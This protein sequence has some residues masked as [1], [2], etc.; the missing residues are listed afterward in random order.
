MWNFLR[1]YAFPLR[2]RYSDTFRVHL[3]QQANSWL[4]VKPLAASWQRYP[5]VVLRDCERAGEFVL[6]DSPGSEKKK[7]EKSQR[8]PTLAKCRAL[9]VPNR[10]NWRCPSHRPSTGCA[11]VLASERQRLCFLLDRCPSSASSS[12]SLRSSRAINAIFC[13]NFTGQLCCQGFVDLRG[14]Q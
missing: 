2:L 12:V 7:S 11:R 13:S 6:V 10:P 4:T 3:Q 1:V 14:S 8:P 5:I 9:S